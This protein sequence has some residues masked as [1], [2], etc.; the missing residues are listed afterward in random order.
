[1]LPVQS[2]FL[3]VQCCHCRRTGCIAVHQSACADP[4]P[5]DP[6]LQPVLFWVGCCT[7]RIFPDVA[8]ARSWLSSKLWLNRFAMERRMSLVDSQCDYGVAVLTMANT[9]RRNALSAAL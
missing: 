9:A 2:T 3:D 1:M 8:H 4:Q 5:S 7:L 6:M